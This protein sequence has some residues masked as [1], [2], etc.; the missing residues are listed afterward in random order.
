MATG[1]AKEKFDELKEESPYKC[2]L[3]DQ[4]FADRAAFERH[5]TRD[6]HGQQLI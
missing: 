6:H 3:C 4:A 5:Q 1:K 2:N